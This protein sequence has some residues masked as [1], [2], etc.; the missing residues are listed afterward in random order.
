M[1]CNANALSHHWPLCYCKSASS[2]LAIS[3][4]IDDVENSPTAD[5][6]SY[7]GLSTWMMCLV[8]MI[9]FMLCA[10]INVVC[11]VKYCKSNGNYA[12]VNVL[13]GS[14]EE[15]EDINL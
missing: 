2:A 12:K 3:D 11:C 13:V 7:F 6:K 10:I 8:A 15:N 5:D 14:D 1:G 4:L 9:P